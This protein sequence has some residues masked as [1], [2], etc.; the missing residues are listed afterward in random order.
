MP[1]FGIEIKYVQKTK[2]F[3]LFSPF[4]LEKILQNLMIANFSRVHIRNVES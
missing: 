2:V 3:D 4:L 1:N